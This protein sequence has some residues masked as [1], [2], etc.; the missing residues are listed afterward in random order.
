MTLEEFEKDI[1]EDLKIRE[2]HFLL[3]NIIAIYEGEFHDYKDYLDKMIDYAEVVQKLNERVNFDNQNFNCQKR[4]YI[5]PIILSEENF[6]HIMALREF[7]EIRN[8]FR[9]CNND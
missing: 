7:K 6:E 9:R 1:A 8:K 3:E 5:T 4:F 2:E